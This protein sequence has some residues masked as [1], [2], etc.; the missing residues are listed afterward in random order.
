[1]QQDTTLIPISPNEQHKTDNPDQESASPRT[2]QAIAASANDVRN[3]LL[4]KQLAGN[5][6][7]IQKM[8]SQVDE[9][10]RKQFWLQFEHT[11]YTDEN[12]QAMALLFILIER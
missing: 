8:L 1:M 5:Q 9:G 2:A 4:S 3:Q 11:K 6:Q 12:K 7:I 10:A